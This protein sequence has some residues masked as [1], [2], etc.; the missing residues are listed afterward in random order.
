MIFAFLYERRGQTGL[1]GT[2]EFKLF[3]HSAKY[4]RYWRERSYPS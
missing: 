4:K 2:I 1:I 3:L